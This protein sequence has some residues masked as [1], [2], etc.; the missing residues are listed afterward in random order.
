MFDGNCSFYICFIC[1]LRVAYK[2]SCFDCKS[3]YQFRT[4]NILHFRK[5]YG[6]FPN[7]FA[8]VPLIALTNNH[9]FSHPSSHKDTCKTELAGRMEQCILNGNAQDEAEPK[10]DT[11]LASNRSN[12]TFHFIDNLSRGSAAIT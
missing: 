11:L 8:Q 9:G 4:P 6:S 2:L 3:T 5:A 12:G 7:I 1:V 10:P